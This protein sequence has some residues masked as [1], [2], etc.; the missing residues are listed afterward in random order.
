MAGRT[1]R[2]KESTMAKEKRILATVY[3]DVETVPTQRQDVAQRIADK[4]KPVIDAD[5]DMSNPKDVKKVLEI[6]A[7]A[8][9]AGTEAYR[10]TSLDGTFGEIVCISFAV[11]DGKVRSFSRDLL[12]SECEVVRQF[13]F[14]MDDLVRDVGA[15]NILYVAHNADFDRLFL[16]KRMTVHRLSGPP[17]LAPRG[18]KPWDLQWQCTMR[19]WCDTPQGR[20]SLADLAL[21]LS[22]PVGKDDLPGS[23]VYDAMLRGEVARVVSHCERDVELVRAVWQRL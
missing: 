13:A 7:K 23:E 8:L 18:E 6:K 4:H 17:G 15:A 2:L 3:V 22:L 19:T 20:I 5:L 12:G 16:T 10:K 14:A 11:D 9:E 21:A 1:N